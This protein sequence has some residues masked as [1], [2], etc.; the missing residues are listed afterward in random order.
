MVFLAAHHNRPREGA[1]IDHAR[2]GQGAAFD[3]YRCR[4]HD[5][6]LGRRDR[7]GDSVLSP[8]AQ[9]SHTAMHASLWRE[10]EVARS[11]HVTRCDWS[12]LHLPRRITKTTMTARLA[13]HRSMPH[14]FRKDTFA[15]CQPGNPRNRPNRRVRLLATA[16]AGQN[17]N[18]QTKKQKLNHMRAATYVGDE[19]RPR[20][21]TSQNAK[22]AT[23]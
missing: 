7:W 6:T 21:Q 20:Y 13:H 15:S 8:V 9:S 14:Q 22:A 3:R 18:V 5:K 1:S 12:K 11:V 2:G 10:T 19:R 4:A 16:T 17:K 23:K